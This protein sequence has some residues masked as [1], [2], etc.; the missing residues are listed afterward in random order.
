MLPFS[1]I[2]DVIQFLASVIAVLLAVWK[3]ARWVFCKARSG[4]AEIRK[5][6]P[7]VVCI[8]RREYEELR[9]SREVLAVLVEHID[10]HRLPRDKAV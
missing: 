7:P 1:L 8:S 2:S 6:R 5:W 4:L 3:C 9:E 10:Q